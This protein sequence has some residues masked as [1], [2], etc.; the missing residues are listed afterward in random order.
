MVT[1]LRTDFTALEANLASFTRRASA[2]LVRLESSM[3]HPWWSSR[4]RRA[5]WALPENFIP[6]MVRS[7]RPVNS[8]WTPKRARASTTGWTKILKLK[9]GL[10]PWSTTKVKFRLPLSW[11]TAPPPDSRR[12]TRMWWASTK[13]WLISSAVF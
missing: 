10:L 1:R 3:M 2:T 4:P 7:L 8:A 9:A 6:S 5:Y 13:A 11:Y 12:A